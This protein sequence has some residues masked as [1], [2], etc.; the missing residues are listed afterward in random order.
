[1]PGGFTAAPRAV[2][3]ERVSSAEHIWDVQDCGPGIVAVQLHD[4][5]G[6]VS[7]TAPVEGM[8][9]HLAEYI[10][11]EGGD[12]EILMPITEVPG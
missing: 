3:K 12:I 10:P 2:V 11:T 1:M 9:W 7:Y 6:T 5:D 4:Y 8:G